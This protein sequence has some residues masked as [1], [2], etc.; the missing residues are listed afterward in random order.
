[1]HIMTFSGDQGPSIIDSHILPYVLCRSVAIGKMIDGK[2]KLYI[3]IFNSNSGP[4]QPRD[5][6]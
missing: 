2:V 4:T 6:L 5:E 3:S 1:M